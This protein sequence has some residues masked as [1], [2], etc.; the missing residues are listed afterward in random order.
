MTKLID[1]KGVDFLHL[2]LE[3][4]IKK[5]CKKFNIEEPNEQTIREIAES[6]DIMKL[7]EG[8]DI[9]VGLSQFVYEDIWHLEDLIEDA[10][11]MKLTLGEDMLLYIYAKVCE[12][13]GYS[14]QDAFIMKQ[15]LQYVIPF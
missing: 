10:R 2:Y 15:S 6:V 12:S 13:V 8:V 5:Y 3:T 14:E 4:E 7:P 1:M 9:F 11:E